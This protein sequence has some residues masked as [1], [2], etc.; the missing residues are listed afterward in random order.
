MIAHFVNCI[1]Y[2]NHFSQASVISAVYPRPYSWLS[3]PECFTAY[4]CPTLNALL[5][6]AGF[7]AP[8]ALPRIAGCSTLNALLRVAGCPTPKALLRISAPYFV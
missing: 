5:R 7:P 8:N 3:Y 1:V 2:V 4:G 6:I